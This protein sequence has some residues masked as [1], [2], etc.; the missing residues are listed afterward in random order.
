MILDLARCNHGTVQ[1]QKSPLRCWRRMDFKLSVDSKASG[2]GFLTPW[3][4]A[5]G[6]HSL[7]DGT[8][9]YSKTGKQNFKDINSSQ[10]RRIFYHTTSILLFRPIFSPATVSTMSGYVQISL[11]HSITANQI[12]VGFT[13]TFWRQNGI[14]CYVFITCN[15]VSPIFE[16]RIYVHLTTDLAHDLRVLRNFDILLLETGR[17]DIQLD[18]LVRLRSWFGSMERVITCLCDCESGNLKRIDIDFKVN[19]V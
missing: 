19:G 5:Q 10:S 1:Q 9:C 16:L 17:R 6:N 8:S 14:S 13:Q 11:D 7:R 15:C 2:K 18:A 4:S 12:A 3:N